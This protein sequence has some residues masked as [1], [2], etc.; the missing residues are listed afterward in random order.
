MFSFK[1]GGGTVR[2][3]N[4]LPSTAGIQLAHKYKAAPVPLSVK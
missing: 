3:L 4:A 1:V 2:R